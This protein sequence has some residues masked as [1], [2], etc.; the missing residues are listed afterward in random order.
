MLQSFAS[1]ETLNLK[2]M[3]Y[4]TIALESEVLGSHGAEDH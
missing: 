1:S 3:T 4:G 2:I